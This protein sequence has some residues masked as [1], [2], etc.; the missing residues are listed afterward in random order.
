MKAFFPT[1]FLIFLA[2]PSIAGDAPQLTLPLACTP[3]KDCFIQQY[4]DVQPGPGA[5]DYRC[6]TA[7]YEGH[8][9]T[10]FRV[11]SVAAATAGVSV[12]AAAAGRV[13][14]ARDSMD[15]RLLAT[16]EDRAMVKGRECGNGVLIDH[17]EGWETQYCHMRRGS[18]KVHE[19]DSV[20]A[21]TPLGLVGFSGNAQFAHLH[22][23][24]RQNG[25]AIDPFLGRPISG[26]CLSGDAPI[27]SSLWT[28]A[29]RDQLTYQDATIIETG[30]AAGP[31]SPEEAE[32]GGITPP[33]PESAALVFYARLIN[34]RQGDSLRFSTEGP[35]DFSAANDSEPLPRPK[36]QYVGFIGKK[37]T[38]ER[39]LAG[40][41]QGRVT[42]IRQGAVI[43]EANA[44]L[45]L[46]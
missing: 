34:M 14:G 40:L 12:L 35:G 7:T 19:G 44:A 43:G 18:V 20:A 29:V 17:G 8:D 42:V 46:P 22:L 38:G 28:A 24:V 30:F 16:P 1:L 21:G 31:V 36:A 3:G 4:V 2:Q 27:P 45:R 26:T 5:K 33:K 10:D 6:G 37:R 11:L 25:K 32:K 9:G 15:D 39:W 41:Y 13:K 23:S